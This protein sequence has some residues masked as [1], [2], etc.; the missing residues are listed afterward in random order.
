MTPETTFTLVFFC[1]G[2]VKLEGSDAQANSFILYVNEIDTFS[3]IVLV[4]TTK[5]FSLWNF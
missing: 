3:S 4:L 5:Q 2:L 1:S